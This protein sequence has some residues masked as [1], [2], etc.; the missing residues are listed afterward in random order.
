M[1][2][3]FHGHYFFLNLKKPIKVTLIGFKII[4]LN[5]QILKKS[6]YIIIVY[7]TI[8]NFQQPLQYPYHRLCIT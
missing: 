1:Q 7:N 6:I 5:Y 2:I 3:D 8:S 4:Y